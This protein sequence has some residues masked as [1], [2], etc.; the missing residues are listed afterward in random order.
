MYR[1]SIPRYGTLTDEYKLNLK[2][3]ENARR[4][5]SFPDMKNWIPPGD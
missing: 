3:A 5:S 4:K 1:K 2:K